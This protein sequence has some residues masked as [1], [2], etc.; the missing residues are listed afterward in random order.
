[1]GKKK[2]GPDPSGFTDPDMSMGQVKRLRRWEKF[3]QFDSILPNR[4]IYKFDS[5]DQGAFKLQFSNYGR[6]LAACCTLGNNKTIIKVWDVEREDENLR[7][8]LQGHN[9]LIHDLDWS[10]NDRFLVSASADGSCKIWNMEKKDTENTCRLS[11]ND[12]DNLDMFFLCE[13][14]HPSFVYGAKFHPMR[15]E[16]MIYVATICFDGKVRIWSVNVQLT[17]MPDAQMVCE[18]SIN[19][20]PAFVLGS[21]KSIYADDDN[22]EDETLR[23]IMNPQ[24]QESHLLLGG[25]NDEKDEEEIKHEQ[26]MKKLVSRKHPNTLAFDNKDTLFVGDSHGQIN[27]WRISIQFQRVTVVDHYLIKHKEIEGD[28]INSIIVH[29]EIQK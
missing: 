23:L 12:P 1:M 14:Q 7:V 29:P 16:S 25:A 5:E 20:A 28:Q 24:D 21:K 2:K 8:V 15:D 26:K 27:V 6:Y 19:D 10:F 13:L 4:L 17:D 3:H 11:Y 9:D 22:L 18:R